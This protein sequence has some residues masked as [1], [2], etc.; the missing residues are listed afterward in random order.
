MSRKNIL[1][2][3]MIAGVLT[4]GVG[5]ASHANVN[6]QTSTN[7]VS[8]VRLMTNR[9]SSFGCVKN[10]N[11]NLVVTNANGK[12]VGYV[13][14]G[15]MLRLGSSNG[16]TTKVTVEETGVTGYI[17]NS[18]IDYIK[19]GVNDSLTRMNRRGMVINVST[20][21]HIR[22][23][24]TMDSSVLAEM[25]NN[26]NLTITGK[27]GDWYRVSVNGIKGFVFGAYIGEGNSI[28][29]GTVTIPEGVHYGSSSKGNRVVVN[30]QIINQANNGT[31][32]NI[33]NN[34]PVV[35][36]NNTPVVV[37][38]N[39]GS[40]ITNNE[41]HTAVVN[42]NNNK[43]NT[44]VN[45]NNDNH[46]TPVVNNNNTNHTTPVVNN[47]NNENNYHNVAQNNN[48]DNH[49]VVQNNNN[50]KHE[51]PVSHTNNDNHT[52]PVVRNNNNNDNH[53]SVDNNGN[54]KTDQNNNKKVPSVKEMFNAY[55]ANCNKVFLNESPDNNSKHLETLSEGAKVEVIGS[56]GNWLK[57]KSGNLVGYIY[58]TYLSTTKPESVKN[59]KHEDI[60]TTP[61][62]QKKTVVKH[63]DNTTPNK[64]EQHHDNKQEP[65]KPN[66]EQPNKQQ[67]H[68]NNNKPNN[69]QHHDNVTPHKEQHHEQPNNE[70]HHDNITP[71]HEQQHDN[72]TTPNKQ[73]EHHEQSN[74]GQPKK[75]QPVIHQEHHDNNQPVN[76]DN[77]NNNKHEQP[78]NN[79]PVNH[80]DNNNHNQPVVPNNNQPIN[81]EHQNNPS[82]PQQQTGPVYNAEESAQALQEINEWR[83]MF[84]Q[85]SI[86][87]GGAAQQYAEQ[88]AKQQI[89]N[90]DFSDN[91]TGDWMSD[92]AWSS[93]TGEEG[94]QLAMSGFKESSAHFNNVVYNIDKGAQVGIAVYTYNG[95]TYIKVITNSND[96][97]NS[98]QM[99]NKNNSIPGL[100]I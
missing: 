84:N 70:Q 24:A 94:L 17:S 1:S 91:T 11:G 46:I 60:H 51:V 15:Q 83:S 18:N 75:E 9:V 13:T 22:A 93:T 73:E 37:N 69:E 59:N 48:N 92:T 79:Q 7:K 39:N 34:V 98:N 30:S 31:S 35:N 78:N 8:N 47:N 14:V 96:W 88:S 54:H 99:T 77:D 100:G 72:N 26:T 56:Q 21:V 62:S 5:L 50:D 97:N 6:K 19:S 27:Q 66:N 58:K 25:T 81:H 49:K 74:N 85:G 87:M 33:S 10:G 90:N 40:H 76:H 68:D 63:D 41:N 12:T 28:S 64:Q 44:I 95:G 23:N 32:S 55:V 71:H 16:G 80:D 67:H 36:N 86:T 61:H 65:A 57:V 3:L 53:K 42:N 2:A 29:G 38:N 20:D 82:R 89:L 43:N 52:T 4:G 45:N